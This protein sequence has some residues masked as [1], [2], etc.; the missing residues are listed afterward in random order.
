MIPNGSLLRV[1][2]PAVCGRV[3]NG[4]RWGAP[5]PPPLPSLGKT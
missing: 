5:H 4:G 1:A 2:A 3:G